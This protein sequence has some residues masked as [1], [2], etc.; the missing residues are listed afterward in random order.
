MVFSFLES[1]DF[2]TSYADVVFFVL[3]TATTSKEEVRRK[4]R[5]IHAK[6]ERKNKNGY[7]RYK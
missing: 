6:N 7:L 2:I 1:F 4:M 3:N 5:H